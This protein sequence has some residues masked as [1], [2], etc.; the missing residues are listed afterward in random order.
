MRK[1]SAFR[2]QESAGKRTTSPVSAGDLLGP[3]AVGAVLAILILLPFLLG[4]VEVKDQTTHL[5]HLILHALL[6]GGL[7]ALWLRTARRKGRE[8]ERERGRE[9][10]LG[11][12]QGPLLAWIGFSALSCYT[13]VNRYVSL[14]ET[15]RWV[16][17]VLLAWLIAQAAPRTGLPL[18]WLAPV[19]AGAAVALLGWRE[20]LESVLWQHDSA[21]RIFATFYNN[22]CLA[23]WLLVV[24]PLAAGLIGTLGDQHPAAAYL[25]AR[26][27]ERPALK[28]R[29]LAGLGV[30]LLLS[31]LLL[32]QSKGGFLGFLGSAL[33]FLGGLK[34]AGRLTFQRRWIW[35]G[36]LGGAV[37]AGWVAGSPLGHRFISAYTTEKHSALHRLLTWQGTWRMIQAHPLVGTGPA[38]F[39]YAYPQYAAASFTAQAHNTFLQIPAEMGLGALAAFLWL[40][41]VMGRECVRAARHREE[42]T[43][44]LLGA[45]GLAALAG[46]ILHNLVDY[47]WSVP[48]VRLTWLTLVGLVAAARPRPA[49]ADGPQGT[50]FRGALSPLWGAVLFL[51]LSVPLVQATMAERWTALGRQRWRE[52]A[53]A[54]AIQA[55]EKAVAWTPANGDAYR[56]LAMGLFARSQARGGEADYRR[57]L[58]LLERAMALQPT[59]GRNY[60]LRGRYQALRG[61]DKEALVWYQQAVNRDPL[62]TQI[63]L[64]LAETHE[65]LGHFGEAERSYQRIVEIQEGPVGQANPTPEYRFDSRYGEALVALGRLAQRR[66]ETPAAQEWLRRG[67]QALDR[68]L[69]QQ[70]KTQRLLDQIRSPEDKQ[71]LWELFGYEPQEAERIRK[72]RQA[73]EALRESLSKR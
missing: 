6:G 27:V 52:G 71:H 45:A 32:T 9:G 22:N 35:G 63:W 48:A 53:V 43:R 30:G 14:I 21:H 40:L 56:E 33:A 34:L 8:G 26:Q 41:G 7:T 62:N 13:S 54:S 55:L 61:Q 11:P 58:Q 36:L 38:T 15:V 28:L 4:K 19:V 3:V 72:L 12:F 16:D 42:A 20:Y 60:Y 66:G 39:P 47:G 59:F 68:F 37:L 1:R 24:L 18:L 10:A 29:I 73:A 2:P 49:G 57:A 25:A 67:V 31:A 64:R 23:A 44:A 17:G 5:P 65:K 46:L 51:L 69:Q 50:R 70:A